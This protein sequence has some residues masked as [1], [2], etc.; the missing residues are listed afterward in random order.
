MRFDNGEY[1]QARERWRV[2]CQVN[3]LGEIE[4]QCSIDLIQPEWSGVVKAVTETFRSAFPCLHS[5]YIRGSVPLGLAKEGSSDIDALALVDGDFGDNLAWSRDAESKIAS[6]FPFLTAAEMYVIPRTAVW[7]SRRTGL[8]IKTQSVCVWG[9]SVIDSI[10]PYRL[11][12]DAF[13]HCLHLAR[14]REAVAGILGSD[15]NEKLVKKLGTKFFKRVLR[16]GFELI[17]AD[18]GFFTRD[19][20]TCCEN[21]CKRWPERRHELERAL[22]YGIFGPDSLDGLMDVVNNTGGWLVNEIGGK[23]K[24]GF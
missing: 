19:L 24:T 5:V 16:S 14:E 3:R 18:V 17:M 12:P 2:V 20:A 22:T 23:Y 8:P 13:T 10:T 9:E 1:K 6:Q 21:M 7:S 4:R 15:Q 11:G